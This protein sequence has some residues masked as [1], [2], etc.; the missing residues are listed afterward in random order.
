MTKQMISNGRETATKIHE[1]IIDGRK[2]IITHHKL[3]CDKSEKALL[4]ITGMVL[5]LRADP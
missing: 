3:A 2:V 5:W 4:H 1:E